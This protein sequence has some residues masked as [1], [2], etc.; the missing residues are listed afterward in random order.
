MTRV[1]AQLRAA[2]AELEQEL[3]WRSAT[4]AQGASQ[5]AAWPFTRP[6]LSTHVPAAQHPAL[7]ILS[8]RLEQ[9][10]DFLK[11]P[12]DGPGVAAA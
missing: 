7:A 9:T 11:Y 12:P 1:G 10:A 5:A 3:A 6:M 4:F 8:A 2:Y